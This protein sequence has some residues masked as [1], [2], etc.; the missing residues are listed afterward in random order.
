MPAVPAWAPT[1]AV[2]PGTGEA[3]GPVRRRAE[4]EEDAP[5]PG[6]LICG[7]CGAGNVPARRYCRRCGAGLADAPVASKPPWW[8]RRRTPRTHAAGERPPRRRRWRLPRPVVPVLLVLAPAVAGYAFRADAWRALESV[9]DRMSKPEQTHASAVT[10]SSAVPGHEAALAV[11][12]TTDRYWAP[13]AGRGEFLEADFGGPLRL[14]D[15][16]VHPGAS[17]VAEKFLREGRP[18]TLLLTAVGKDGRTTNKTVRLA[19]VPGEQR[20]HF[21]VSDVVRLRIT[22][23]GSYGADGGRVVALG[24]VEFFKRR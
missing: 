24:E 13:G 19:D 18:G 9:R 4:A 2:Q 12:G 17:P 7:R 16:V 14:L 22:V 3:A 15:L 1:R 6:E 5:R 23:L 21:A 20:F 8:R 10:A 11:D